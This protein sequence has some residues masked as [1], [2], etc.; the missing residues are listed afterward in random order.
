M[1]E[2]PSGRRS[3]ADMLRGSTRRADTAVLYLVSTAG[4][5]NYGDELITRAWLDFLAEHRPSAEVW[6]DCPHPG[7]VAHL[8]KDTHPRL[9]VTNTLWELALGSVSH[10]PVEDAARIASLVR[11]L[12]SPRFDAGL[13]QLREAASVHVLGG[14][15]LN[16]M[17]QDNLGI[18]AALA[19]LRRSFGVRVFATG[20]GL[21]PQNERH[22]DWL[23]EQLSAFSLIE[24]RD[25][26]TAQLVGAT[27][28]LDDAFLALANSRPV[29]DARPVP[30]RM[31][32]VQGDLQAWDDAAAAETIGAFLA[33]ADESEVGFVEAV[34]PDDSRYAQRV[35]PGARFYP[36]GHVWADGLPARAG[37]KW[38]TSRFHAHLLA[39]AAGAAGI[40]IEGMSGYYDVKHRSLIER[41]TGWSIVTAGDLSQGLE[42]TLD[43][44]F[45]GRARG[46]ASEKIALAR[47]LYAE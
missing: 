15:Y 35:R 26:E 17:W 16:A 46:F 33:D 27:S 29:F 5:P 13:L 44:S 37:Q 24:A 39:A 38:L 31:V 1:K 3:I 12:G 22:R 21:L 20:Q 10:D 40:V 2:A 8:M 25:A 41:G 32:L 19:E 47:R 18:I 36:F 34:P 45:P 11:D 28:G 6:L 9:R 42:P 30:E 23:I 7:R 14:G 4:H 43:P